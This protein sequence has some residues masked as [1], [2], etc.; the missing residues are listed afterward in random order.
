MK[1]LAFL[2]ALGVTALGLLALPLGLAASGAASASASTASGAGPVAAGF[3]A[4]L[5]TAYQQAATRAPQLVPACKGMRWQILAGVAQVESDQASG[6][7]IAADG[8]ITP[9]IIGPRLDGTGAGGNTTVVRDTDHGRWDS[10]TVYDH[11]IGPFQF[12]PS[13]W[14]TDGLNGRGTAAA[15]DP[16]N[17]FDAALTAAVYLCGNGR[18][19]TQPAALHDALYAYNHSNAYVTQ[20]EAAITEF[21]Q[22]V[23]TSAGPT[24]GRAAIV[25]RA[26]LSQQGVPYSW[27]GGTAHG[28]SRGICCSNG[29]QNGS[30]IVGFD[31]S[32]LT[33][34]AYA[35]AGITLPRLASDQA[36]IGHRIPASAGLAALHPGDLIFYGYIPGSDSSIYHVAIYLGA[37]KQV[38][39]PRPG[40]GVEVEPVD[41]AGGSYAGGISIV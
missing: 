2:V 4:V 26:A 11:A 6:H 24:S 14:A 5:A 32:G 25:I 37:G 40:L 13:T 16:E 12:L 35:Q 38:A 31:C 3:P 1:T 10:D 34:Y 36:G 7:S 28:P 9:P 33:L 23:P 22:Q 19:L 41:I 15:P 30:L 29:G 27:G 39:A 21:D 20:V 8:E 18:D 17:A